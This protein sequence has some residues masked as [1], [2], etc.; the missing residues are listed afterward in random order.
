MGTLQ[1]LEMMLRMAFT[2]ARLTRSKACQ[3]EKGNG[4]DPL[5]SEW[6][7]VSPLIVSVLNT[8]KDT[9]GDELPDDPT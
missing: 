5:N 2:P 4:P 9:G 3:D 6:N 8:K 1:V 7:F